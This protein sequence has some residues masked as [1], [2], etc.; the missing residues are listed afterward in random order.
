MDAKPIKTQT[1]SL[2]RRDIV[3][4]QTMIMGDAAKPISAAE[5]IAEMI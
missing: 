4:P 3:V 1:I 5:L 2:T